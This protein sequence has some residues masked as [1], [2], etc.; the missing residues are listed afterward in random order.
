MRKRKTYNLHKLKNGPQNTST[1][2][3]ILYFLHQPKEKVKKEEISY[4]KAYNEICEK[5]KNVQS[6]K[7]KKRTLRSKIL[8]LV[9]VFFTSTKRKSKKRRN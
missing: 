9:L 3:K 4:K 1:K 2:T 6:T 5:E 7:M 8:L